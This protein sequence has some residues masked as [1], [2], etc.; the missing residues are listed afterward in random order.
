M[1]TRLADFLK[2]TPEGAEAERI[3]RTCVHC[4][5]CLATCPTY[6]VLGDEQDSPRGRIYLMKQVMEGAAATRGTQLH[7][8]RCLTC[9]ACESTCPSGVQYGKL[10]DIG[11]ELVEHQV[12][13]PPQER[14]ARLAL[15]KLLPRRQLF[16]SLLR[17][18][19]SVRPL[20]P[21]LLRSKVPVRRSQPVWPQ[22]ARSRHK[23][24]ML[25]GCVQPG[26]APEINV[27]T[28]RLLADLGLELVPASD[29][30][31]GAVSQHLAAP[32]EALD[33][34]R[35][36]IDVWW[37]HVEA[38]AEA[39]I[40][41]ASGCGTQVKEYGYLLRDDPAYAGK[42]ARISAL[43]RDPVE[44]FE[45]YAPR[46][47]PAQGAPRRIAFQAPCT[48]Q[49]GQRLSGRVETLL[50]RIGFELTPVA[51]PHLC[52]GSAGTYSVLQPKLSKA[53]LTRKLGALQAGAPELIASANIG[54]II[55]MEP[56]AAVP[57][58]HWLE[59]VRVKEEA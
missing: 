11:R 47:E 10:V 36:N 40:V 25:Q 57:V 41:N 15:R 58:R 35:H 37:P 17:L 32:A 54:C 30:C 50:Q 24:L 43:A 29:G 28:A 45:T 12:P 55:H 34:V 16:T 53:L 51:D 14:L 9:R 13:R 23:V 38:G 20:L 4:G 21:G 39:I 7:L 48:L 8:D 52:C 3:L 31:C 46:L 6:Q 2:Q 27:A 42:A 22:P 59:L 5:F 56:G 33:Y 1:Q 26:L 19:Q 49:H 44:L 18:G